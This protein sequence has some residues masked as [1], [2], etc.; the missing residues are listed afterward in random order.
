[1]KP[2]P[3]NCTYHQLQL[4]Q[5]SQA[6]LMTSQDP[7]YCSASFPDFLPGFPVALQLHKRAGIIVEATLTRWHHD[8]L[9]A[10]AKIPGGPVTTSQDIPNA[11]AS[12]P[13]A[14]RVSWSHGRCSQKQAIHRSN[15]LQVMAHANN[16]NF[17]KVLGGPCDLP[18]P[19]RSSGIFPWS[20][21]GLLVDQQLRTKAGV[22]R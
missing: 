7:S 4:L 6:V 10:L 1:M 21:L 5:N 20:L 16:C 12:F 15:H 11:L 17:C 18:R 8:S 22:N 14:C 2:P 13:A 9:S 3:P 19:S